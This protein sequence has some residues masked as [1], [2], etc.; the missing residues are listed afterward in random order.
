MRHRSLN[1][2]PRGLNMRSRGLNRHR[3]EHAS[4]GLEKV[5][6]WADSFNYDLNR[7]PRGVNIRPIG[8]N[9]HPEA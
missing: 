2:H 8:L 4:R 1:T 5:P 3:P 7:H 9:M 6:W